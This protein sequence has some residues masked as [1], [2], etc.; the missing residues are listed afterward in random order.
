MASV[1]KVFI[2]GRMGKD[3]EVRYTQDGSAV[4][5]LSIATTT[6]SKES[7]GDKK[8]YTE[9]HRCVA[10]NKAADVAGKYTKKG[11]L[12]FIEGSLRTK[13]WDDNGTTRYATE[14]VVGRLQLLGNKHE[15]EPV[16]ENAVTYSQ[17]DD[18]PF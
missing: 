4:T 2:L 10:F 7:N 11:D 13:K 17:L 3:P 9:W 5:T 8:E 6:V 18:N 14:I 16:A 15:P 1:N 12:I